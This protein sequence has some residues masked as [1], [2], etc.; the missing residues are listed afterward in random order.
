MTGVAVGH[1]G[2]LYV[3]Q[4]FADPSTPGL[5]GVLTR[6]KGAQRTN[7]DVPFPAGVV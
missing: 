6:V 1:D 4:L 7:V 2:E 5:P 3:S